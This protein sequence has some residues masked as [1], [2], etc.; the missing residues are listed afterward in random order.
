MRV[1]HAA[2]TVTLGYFT[3]PLARL[4]ARI[5][6]DRLLSRLPEIRLET[7][8]P[9]WHDELVTRSMKQL[10]ISYVMAD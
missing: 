8:Q 6:F 7:P 1:C 4:E 10:V 2:Y 9:E 3:T 5:A